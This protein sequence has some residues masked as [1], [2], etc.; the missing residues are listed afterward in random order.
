MKHAHGQSWRRRRGQSGSFEGTA[1]GA[2]KST[3]T[4]IILNGEL[5]AES[6]LSSREVVL[7]Q[8]MLFD[9]QHFRAGKVAPQCREP[10]IYTIRKT[11]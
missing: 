9:F 8:F 1:G 2:G 6:N 7:S 11:T 5:S 3:S 4:S 10:P